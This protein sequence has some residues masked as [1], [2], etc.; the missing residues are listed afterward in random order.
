[1]MPSPFASTRLRQ[2][3]ET[4][5]LPPIFPHD[6]EIVYI[7]RCRNMVC[8]SRLGLYVVTRGVKTSVL[9]V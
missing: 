2:I 9:G 4:L 7:G 1:M 5:P 6:S 8:I 3:L